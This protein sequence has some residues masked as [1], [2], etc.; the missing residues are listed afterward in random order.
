M[1]HVE[2]GKSWKMIETNHPKSHFILETR[3]KCHES[4][5]GEAY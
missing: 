2:V 4:A 1:R 5:I 3:Q